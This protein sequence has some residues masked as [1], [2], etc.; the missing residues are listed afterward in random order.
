VAVAVVDSS[1]STEESVQDPNNRNEPDGD[2]VFEG[3]ES[4]DGAV[5]AVSSWLQETKQIRTNAIAGSA[6]IILMET[7]LLEKNRR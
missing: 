4:F 5:D 1:R 7:K 6:K 2:S 3:E